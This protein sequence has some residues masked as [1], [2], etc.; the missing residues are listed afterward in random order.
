MEVIACSRS[1]C[2]EG[3]AIGQYVSLQTLLAES[4]VISLH[5][6]LFP[7]TRGI[8]DAGAIARMKDGA[9][10]LNTARGPLV[11]ESHVAKYLSAAWIPG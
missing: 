3:E 11:A 5:C 4:D 6:P 10:L 7:E 9:I 8:I 2:A 1:R